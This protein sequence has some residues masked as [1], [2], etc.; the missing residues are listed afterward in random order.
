[1]P[2][3]GLIGTLRILYANALV[4]LAHKHLSLFSIARVPPPNLPL[5]GWGILF[6]WEKSPPKQNQLVWAPGWK[7]YVR[8]SVLSIAF[9]CSIQDS[10]RSSWCGFR[11]LDASQRHLRVLHWNR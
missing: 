7:A 5:V 10:N 9:L 3:V 8:L 11:T 2:L 4:N 6:V 1:M